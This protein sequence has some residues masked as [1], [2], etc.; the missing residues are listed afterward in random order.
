MRNSLMKIP[1]VLA[2]LALLPAQ[3]LAADSSFADP[4]RFVGE[5]GEEIYGGICQGCHMPDGKGASGAGSYPALA[6]N[7][8]LE[9]PDYPI[10]VVVHGQKAMPPFGNI[11]TDPQI[12][13]V[14]GYIRTH[15]GNAYP[16]PVSAEDV[17]S[18]R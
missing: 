3:A 8:A 2:L 7:G 10:N 13:A 18:A 14:V 1:I 4:S 17:R 11:L 12:A 16:E 9:S 5:T 6:G 15:F